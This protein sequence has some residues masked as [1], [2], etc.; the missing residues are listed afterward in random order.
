MVRSSHEL[1]RQAWLC[2][3]RS[4]VCALGHFHLWHHSLLPT[5]RLVMFLK[6]GSPRVSASPTHASG[7]DSRRKH[8]PRSRSHPCNRLAS[9]GTELYRAQADWGAF[10]LVPA[11]IYF[12]PL[13]NWDVR[14]VDR[15]CKDSLRQRASQRWNW[16]MQTAA[17]A[18]KCESGL[19]FALSRSDEHLRCN[20]ARQHLGSQNC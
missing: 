15:E 12:D 13:V 10:Y 14:N 1:G 11:A 16:R 5:M 18:N 8:R 17:G 7:N 3:S 2:V 20:H 19:G 4:E 9:G 6:D